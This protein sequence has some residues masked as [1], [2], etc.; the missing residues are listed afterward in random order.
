MHIDSIPGNSARP[1]FSTAID[2]TSSGLESYSEG[3]LEFDVSGAKEYLVGHPIPIES[4]PSQRL[5]DWMGPGRSGWGRGRRASRIDPVRLAGAN[6][7]IPLILV[8]VA[9]RRYLI[10]GHHR[11]EL[12][13]RLGRTDFPVVVICESAAVRR[14]IRARTSPVVFWWTWSVHR[15]IRTWWLRERGDPVRR[16]ESVP[17]LSA[18]EPTTA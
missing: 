1:Q 6:V 8:E 9:H 14:I 7:T 11:L 12:G 10:D 5:Y 2:W 18:A 15:R 17:L 4:F 13:R 16:A 3:T